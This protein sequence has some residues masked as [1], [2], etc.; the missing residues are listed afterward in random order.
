MILIKIQEEIDLIY[1]E[2]MNKISKQDVNDVMVLD[3]NEIDNEIIY[4]IE[5]II[6]MP[7]S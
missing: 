5:K 7:N 3:F 4:I 6:A 1:D 2:T